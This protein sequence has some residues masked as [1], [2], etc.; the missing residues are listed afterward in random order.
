LTGNISTDAVLASVFFALLT[1]GDTLI[2]A[3]YKLY[4]TTIFIR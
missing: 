3:I 4:V 2:I 1:L